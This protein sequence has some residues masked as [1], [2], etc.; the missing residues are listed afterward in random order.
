MGNRRDSY[1]SWW[2]DPR[3]R[4]CLRDLHVDNIGMVLQE[5]GWVGMD[6]IDVSQHKGN[7]AV[8]VNVVINLNF[9]VAVL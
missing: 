6:W 2:E 9:F 1:R 7:R 8:A 3:A 5:L 4:D